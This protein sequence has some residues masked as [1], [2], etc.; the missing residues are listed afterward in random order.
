RTVRVSFDDGREVDEFFMPSEIDFE[1]GD[2]RLRTEIF[3]EGVNLERI[4][5]DYR[6]ITRADIVARIELREIG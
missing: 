6:G 3:Q 4:S 2:E 1:G 5:S